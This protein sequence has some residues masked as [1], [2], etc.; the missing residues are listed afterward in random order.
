MEYQYWSFMMTH[1][2]HTLLPSESVTEAIDVL[3]W[4]YTG[5]FPF[6]IFILSFIFLSS[7]RL[8]PSTHPSLPPF[9]QE[10]CQELLT[11]LRSFN[12]KPPH[13][14]P[15]LFDIHVTS[16]TCLH[17]PCQSFAHVLYLKYLFASVSFGSP[18]RYLVLSGCLAA[19]RQGRLEDDAT[20]RRNHVPSARIPFLRTA[21][22]FVISFVCL[23]LPY[24]FLERSHHQRFDTESGVRSN[25]GP[26]LVVGALACLIVSWGLLNM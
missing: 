12:R 13:S 11:L 21:G 17:R 15:R 25:A 4:S 5:P 23:G 10:E 20:Y 18:T 7:D 24:L 14:V 2:A 3:T 8:L 22:D 26:M 19:W 6:L 1:P 16:Q 9:S